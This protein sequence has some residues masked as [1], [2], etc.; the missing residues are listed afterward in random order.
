MAA[1]M[2]PAAAGAA[3]AVGDVD[4]VAGVTPRSPRSDDSCRSGCGEAALAP[5]PFGQRH[6][7]SP[8]HWW[9]HEGA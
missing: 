5:A 8:L 6:L 1:R 4:A 3:G 2:V 9:A 7:R